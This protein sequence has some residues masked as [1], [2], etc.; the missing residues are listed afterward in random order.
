MSLKDALNR[1]VDKLTTGPQAQYV[2]GGA[3]V[4]I[5]V[6]SL[7]SVFVTFRG[8]EHPEPGEMRGF[9]LETNQEFVIDPKKAGPEMGGYPGMMMG[10]LIYSPFTK[11]QTAVRMTR[12]PNCKT[13]FVPAYLKDALE[14]KKRGEE[15]DPMMHSPDR[16]TSLVCPNCKTDVIQWWREHRR[17]RR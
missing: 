14:R 5:I 9:C 10:A 2:L 15:L 8:R 1:L 17:E 4:V 13:W 12:C 11:E 6:L 16:D 7:I 3:L